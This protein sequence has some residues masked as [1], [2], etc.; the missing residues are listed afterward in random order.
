[1]ESHD[2]SEPMKS[3]GSI[4]GGNV[5]GDKP[6]DIAESSD[7]EVEISLELSG[8]DASKSFDSVEYGAFSRFCRFEGIGN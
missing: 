1:M 6:H 5:N 8:E 3:C 4:V 7:Q 2:K